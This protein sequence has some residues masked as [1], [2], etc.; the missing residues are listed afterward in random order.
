M[1][2]KRFIVPVL[3]TAIAFCLISSLGAGQKDK[4]K[5]QAKQQPPQEK[6]FIPKEI[7]AMMAEGMATKQGR[8]DIPVSVFYSMYLPAQQNFHDTFFL[9]LKNSALGFAPLTAAPATPAAPPKKGP[10]VAAQQEPSQILQANFNMFVQFNLIKENAKPEDVKEVYI[11]CTVQ[12][13]S[14][15]FDPE[16]EDTYT[17]GYP[18]P[19]GHY[20][21]AFAVTSVDLKKVGIAYYDF[22]V[23]ELSTYAKAMDTTPV[24]FVKQMDQMESVETR[25]VLHRGFFTYSI[26]KIYPNLEKTFS[27]GQNVDI[28]FFIFGTQ[29]NAQNQN[30]IEVT[31]EVKKG[32]QSSIKWA[33]QTY[34]NPLISQPLPLKQTLSVKSASGERTESKD[35]PPGDYTLLIKILDKVSNKTATKTIDFTMK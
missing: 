23:P 14:A 30:E 16:A 35:L 4:G 13:P 18:M 33:S 26:L 22:N 21:L 6:V 27:A 12:V 29:A 20:L 5:P 8:Q 24:F 32:E 15:G 2:T 31:F 10:Q 11:P 1:R 28:F 25:T 19:A 17:M 3:V 7:K 9:K 34:S